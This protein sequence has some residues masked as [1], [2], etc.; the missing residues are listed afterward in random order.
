MY[1]NHSGRHAFIR[2]QGA[3]ARKQQE[4]DLEPGRQMEQGQDEIA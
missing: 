3:A 1:I 4:S 2:V